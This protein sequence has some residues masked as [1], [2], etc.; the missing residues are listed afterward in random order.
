MGITKRLKYDKINNADNIIS[1]NLNNGY[2]IIALTGNINENTYTTTLFLKEHTIDNWMLIDDVE[3]LVFDIKPTTNIN[4]VIL[5]KVS[6]LL[7][8]NFFDY[9][10]NR[11]E[12]ELKCYEKGSEIIEFKEIHND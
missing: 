3:K 6:D 2:E 7:S 12:Y 9:Y 4:S 10:I 1:I 8:E 5:K 11:Y